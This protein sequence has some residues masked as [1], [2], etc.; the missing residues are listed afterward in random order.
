MVMPRWLS[1]LLLTLLLGM[2]L[3]TTAQDDSLQILKLMP[4]IR[5]VGGQ[6]L[7]L[8]VNGMTLG[9]DRTVVPSSLKVTIAQ[10]SLRADVRVRSVL[11]GMLLDKPG[12]QPQ[13]CQKITF[14]IPSG[15]VPGA[16]TIDF[17]WNGRRSNSFE[18]EIGDKLAPL[19]IGASRLVTVPRGTNPLQGAPASI[20]SVVP[21]L[22]LELKRGE[23]ASFS[24]LPLIDE[25]EVPDAAILVTFRQGSLVLNAIARIAHSPGGRQGN[26]YLP[27]RDEV[28]IK[29]PQEL[30]TGEL[31]ILLQYRLNGKVSDP[32][33]LKGVIRDHEHSFSS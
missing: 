26:M 11:P 15:L 13:S 9:V 19:A 7:D 29:T 30:M 17:S 31:D 6:I 28:V 3:R 16:A 8:Y 12:G 23:E 33:P 20:G 2:P 22:V 18:F 21:G 4:P 1:C 14:T 27:P 25:A 24:V 5:P 32:V 10:R